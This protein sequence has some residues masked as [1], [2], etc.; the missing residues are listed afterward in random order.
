MLMKKLTLLFVLLLTLTTS[1]FALDFEFGLGSGYVLY[2]GKH[3]KSLVNGFDQKSQVILS[4]D[5]EMKM[6][7]AS[8]LNL[9]FGIDSI[10]DGRWK[11]SHHIYLW[12]YACSAGVDVYPGIGGLRCS[13]KYC[14]GRRTDFVNLPEDDDIRSTDF[15]NGFE[16]AAGWDFGWGRSG[17]SPVVEAAWR[18]M[19]RGGASDNVLDLKLKLK[20]KT[21]N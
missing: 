14:L 19:P 9:T 13:V 2:G 20:F 3:V 7:V 12:D 1:A 18:H 6:P 8:V 11:G 21:S 15:G 4:T 5:V 10:F 16:F 17:L